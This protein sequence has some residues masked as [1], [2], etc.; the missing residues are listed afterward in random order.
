MKK[1]LQSKHTTS[2]LSKFI[3]GLTLRKNKSLERHMS[4]INVD[5]IVLEALQEKVKEA[6]NLDDLEEEDSVL[7][8]KLQSA[9]TLNIL[10]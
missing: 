2:D 6:E 1:T 5:P 8:D 3:R 10:G 7:Y 4:V 9:T